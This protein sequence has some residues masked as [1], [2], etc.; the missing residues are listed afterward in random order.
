MS[1]DAQN[2]YLLY[3]DRGVDKR[4]RYYDGQFLGSA[5]FLLA[6]A[7]PID[8]HRRHLANTV[9]PGV[10]DGYAVHGETDAVVIAPGTAVDHL[11]RP[12]VLTANARRAIQAADR[13]KNLTLWM[14]YKEEASDDSAEDKGAS[15]LT[16]FDETPEIMYTADGNALPD[17][18]LIIA[19][20]QVDAEGNVNVDTGV[21]PRAGLRVPG[22]I[23][24]TLTGDDRDPGRGT[25]DGALR[26]NVPGG[27]Q[28]STTQPALDV[29]GNARVRHGMTIGQDGNSGYK[30]VTNDGN[31][32][33]VN[34]QLAAGGSGG[35][36][37][38]KLGIGYG[39][40]GEGEGTLTAQRLAL[41]VQQADGQTLRVN[42][43]ARFHGYT[44]FDEPVYLRKELRVHAGIDLA[45]NAD[46][47]DGAAGQIRYK[48]WT[49]GLDIVGAGNAQAERQI[50]FH[51]QGGSRHIGNLS[52]EGH[53]VTTGD[54]NPGRHLQAARNITAGGDATIAGRTTTQTLTINGDA[55]SNALFDG[56]EINVRNRLTTQHLTATGGSAVNT[57]EV[58]GAAN[59]NGNVNVNGGVLNVAPVAHFAARVN[60]NGDLLKVT[61]RLMP[62]VGSDNTKGIVWPGNPGG[63]SGDVAA[64]R[65]YAY[66]GQNTTLQIENGD[67]PDDVITLRQGGENRIVVRNGRV[68]IKEWNPST[69]LHVT[70]GARVTNVLAV[71][72]RIQCDGPIRPSTG[73]SGT[74]GIAWVNNAFGG[75]GDFARIQ[76]ASWGGENAALSL[77][78]GND[79]NDII[80]LK[81][82]GADRLTVKTGR[83]GINHNN[84]SHS[85]TVGGA[86]YITG[87]TRIDG[88][89][90]LGAAD[91]NR[92]A[93]AGKICYKTHSDDALEI[94]GGG[95][96][97]SSNRRVRVWAENGLVVHGW[98]HS[99][100]DLRLHDNSNNKAICSWSAS[101]RVIWGAVKSDGSRWCGE[102]FTCER[103]G[104][105]AGAFI[106]RFNPKFSSRPAA[107]VTQHYP[108]NNDSSNSF[109]NTRD[110]AVVA[111]TSKDWVIVVTGD[112]DGDRTHRSFEFIVIGRV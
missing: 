32:L 26:I 72:G 99:K 108:N 37:I 46:G 89:L 5:D 109:G 33:V 56:H 28:H 73:T 41:G 54:V 81:Q 97:N 47:G 69:D 42:G 107:V 66:S 93:N 17:G 21:R 105:H 57:L 102:G 40:P 7:H 100:G 75:S 95:G 2:P 55:R 14:R 9:T 101:T 59:L 23:P 94:I 16:R 35:S 43:A 19:R 58:G 34:G 103:Y 50:T 3:P 6:Q 64:I 24:I 38:Y 18:V 106:I 36:A 111:R 112:G 30:N 65:Y 85:L 49:D 13:S 87:N 80:V 70:G 98:M 67:D 25:L 91:A 53:H 63:G 61:N 51:A 60:A 44:E 12:M 86:T 68:G 88:D 48:R 62:S 10:L 82:N 104:N 11:G 22:P 77:T 76:Y 83:V 92:E 39:P 78:V 31:D 74:N 1:D 84:P 15:G 110:N 71:N 79:A 96:P 20:L 52:V 29:R 27:T 8:R 90:D 45:P 4:V